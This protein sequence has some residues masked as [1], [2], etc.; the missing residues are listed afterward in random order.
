MNAA[1]GNAA[2]AGPGRTTQPRNEHPAGLAPLQSGGTVPALLVCGG[3]EQPP[4]QPPGAMAEQQPWLQPYGGLP[5]GAWPAPS[6]S[7]LM[8]SA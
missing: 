7:S 3:A 5:E 1:V 2:E 8:W 4:E 6:W